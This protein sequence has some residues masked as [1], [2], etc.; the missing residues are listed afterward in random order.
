MKKERMIMKYAIACD[1]GTG[2]CK[3][4]LY[5][6][7]GNCLDG[8]FMEY[9]T[10]YPG[11]SMHEQKPEEWWTAV[12]ESIRGLLAGKP[13]E[14]RGSIAGIGL[15]GHSL[16]MVALDETGDLILDSV[17]IWSDGRPGEAEL[18]PF[19][20]RVPENEWYMLTGN[21]F[22]PPLYTVFKIL[23]MRNHQPDA[24]ARCAKIIGTKDYINYRLCGAVATDYSYAS[25][26]GVYDLENW[27]YSDR[28]IQAA[29]LEKDLFPEI[30]ASSDVLGTLTPEAAAE[31]G[32]SGSVK[33]VAGGVDNS[34][35]ALGAMCFRDG[36]IYNSLGSSSWIAV[37]SA[38]PLLDLENRPYVFTHVVPGLFASATAIFSAG[39]SH[40]WF[41][42]ILRN[43]G[44]RP[45]Y[46]ELD[47]EA[48]AV[49]AG[50]GNL[51]FNP[52]LAG[53]SS[54]DESPEIKG[55]FLGLSLSHGR[56]HLV[57]AVMEGVGYGLKVALDVLR[58]LTPTERRIT[59]VGGGSKS[60]LWCQ[61]L[62]DI[63]EAE[64]VK[65]N[66]DEQAAALGAASLV[67]VGC[68]IWEDFSG[69]D[70][71]HQEEA[72]YHCNDANKAVYRSILEIYR[73]AS[74]SLAKLGARMRG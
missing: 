12:K 69:I 21:G 53:G 51:I 55:A 64:I 46:K 41:T 15:S 35:M 60:R 27:G 14:L 30:K 61:I 13:D 72:V 43:G 3:S 45:G 34:C 65:T 39:S 32:L 33:V 40:K 2:G 11:E 66:I 19:F 1:L 70:E 74:V 47:R 38:K 6:S 67:L 7:G 20:D 58:N 44:D 18:K 9:P 31:L 22:P 48:S 25:G 57:R 37:S 23:W 10:Y 56:A 63:Y 42:G 49:P 24:F 68:G 52:S 36:R 73:D 29:G 26:S 50:S 4:S 59:L 8:L 54:L 5:D 71:L 62:A 28:L 16:G 17:P